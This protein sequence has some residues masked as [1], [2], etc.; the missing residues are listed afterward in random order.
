MKQ[1]EKDGL[2]VVEIINK[3]QIVSFVNI[4]SFGMIY[5]ERERERERE[6][7]LNWLKANNSKLLRLF[8]TK[9][10]RKFV[11]GLRSGHV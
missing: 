4:W 1:I 5:A 2:T 9:K 10:I 6:Y 7:T 3:N 8:K 11:V